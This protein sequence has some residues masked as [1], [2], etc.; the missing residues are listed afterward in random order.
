MQSKLQP[1]RTSLGDLQ[2]PVERGSRCVLCAQS[3]HNFSK[4]A[5]W[6]RREEGGSGL[7]ESPTREIRSHSHVGI[8]VGVK[9]D[10]SRGE[11]AG[12]LGG[13]ARSLSGVGFW[14]MKELEG[15][16]SPCTC[17]WYDGVLE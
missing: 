3:Q 2:A 15:S 9:E 5:V 16:P 7:E 14:T 6:R 12:W 17:G 4:A 13:P 8:S 10:G 1:S 11:A